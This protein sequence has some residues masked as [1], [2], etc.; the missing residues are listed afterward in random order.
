[1]KAK[2]WTDAERARKTAV[3]LKYRWRGKAW[4]AEQVALLGTAE[5]AAIA[6]TIG[7]RVNAV[8]LNRHRLGVPRFTHRVG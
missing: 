3:N 6:Y 2:E 7:R 1:M 8:A 4:T 5:D